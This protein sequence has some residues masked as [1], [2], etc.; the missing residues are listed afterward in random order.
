[1]TAQLISIWIMIPKIEL[2]LIDEGSVT[3]F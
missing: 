1:V 2:I 3:A